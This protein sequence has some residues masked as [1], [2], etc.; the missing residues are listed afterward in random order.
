[1]QDVFL[2]LSNRVRPSGTELNHLMSCHDK[3]KTAINDTESAS[4]PDLFQQG[5]Q[6]EVYSAF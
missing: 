5:M 2:T 1:M 3:L 6:N 4:N